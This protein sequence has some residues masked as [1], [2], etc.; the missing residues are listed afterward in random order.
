[1][2]LLRANGYVSKP[3]IG[4]IPD[5][6][7]SLNRK[8][9]IAQMESIVIP[10][11]EKLEGYTMTEFIDYLSE[12]IKKHDPTGV[13]INLIINPNLKPV[14]ALI[15]G[16]PG[17]GAVPAIDPATGL[18]IAPVG[19]NGPIVG[20]AAFNPDDVKIVGLKNK[21]RG[22]TVAQIIEAVTQAYDTP[23]Q[24]VVLN[25]G[26]MFIS[27]PADQVGLVNRNFRFNP[28]AL[29]SGQPPA[30]GIPIPTVPGRPAGGRLTG[31][32]P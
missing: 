19:G 11:I 29:G 8:R 10:E 2:R 5:A 23:I 4:G 18:P 6:R 16:V 14:G 3:H 7:T 28:N 26:V 21:L 31:P 1:M 30:G 32:I 24:Y 25:H 9:I 13:G 15:A 17:G 12:L 27:M 22:L 20:G